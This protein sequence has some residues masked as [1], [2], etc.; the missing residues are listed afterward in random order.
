MPTLTTSKIESWEKVERRGGQ[1][2]RYDMRR[3]L[4]NYSAVVIRNVCLAKA[5]FLINVVQGHRQ[6]FSLSFCGCQSNRA[7]TNTSTQTA[8][9][10]WC[11]DRGV[12]GN[13]FLIFLWCIPE[14]RNRRANCTFFQG[15][16][17]WH[18]LASPPFP[19][20]QEKWSG[21]EYLK[22]D[23]KNLCWSNQNNIVLSTGATLPG[24]LSPL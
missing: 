21:V 1:V 24:S 15:A 3:L 22:S 19:W 14:R 5:L 12:G 10:F 23:I 9:N 2:R 16:I 7:Y 6:Q 8:H 18:F 11:V 4:V 13:R 20:R 17:W